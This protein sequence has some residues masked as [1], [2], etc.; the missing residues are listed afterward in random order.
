MFICCDPAY[1][2]LC[3]WDYANKNINHLCFLWND[4]YCELLNINLKV[5]NHRHLEYK[6][7]IFH[8]QCVTIAKEHLCCMG[9]IRRWMPVLTFLL[10]EV[11]NQLHVQILSLSA[12]HALWLSSYFLF[13]D[14]LQQNGIWAWFEH[15]LSAQSQIKQLCKC[16][17][18]P[19][20]LVLNVYRGSS[21]GDW[22]TS[23]GLCY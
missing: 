6:K 14:P 5:P 2:L 19:D 3:L 20:H 12:V 8:V 10:H 9:F 13:S 1:T 23:R 18:F 17:D 4:C 21:F 7:K 11:E 22:R 15:F 16:E